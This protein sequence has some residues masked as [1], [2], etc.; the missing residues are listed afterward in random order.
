M[1]SSTKKRTLGK[2][3]ATLLT[4]SMIVGTGLYV[5]LGAA[6]FEAQS[7]ILIAMII[8]GII[9]LLTGLSGAQVG[10]NYPEEG[11]AFNWTR[12]FG[13][14]TISFIAGF[15]YLFD[16]VVGI[17]VLALGF[18]T[19]SAQVFPWL[20]IPLIASIAIIAVGAI[21]YFGIEPTSRVLIGIFLL[22]LILLGVYIAF[23][24]PKIQTANFSN[25]FGLGVGGILSGAATFFWAWDGFQRTAIMADEIKEPRKTIPFAVVVGITLAAAVYLIVAATTLGVLGPQKMGLTD[26]PIFLAAALTL[27]IGGVWLVFSSAWMTSFS[28]ML[29]DLLPTSK[30]AHSMGTEKEL[31]HQFGVLNKRFNS[32]QFSLLALIIIGIIL[33]TLFP[34]R[35]LIPIASAFTL[36][37]YIATHFSALKLPRKQHFISPIFSWLGLAACIG[38]IAFLPLWSIAISLAILAALAG[39]RWLFRKKRS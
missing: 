38:L 6:T 7:G 17:G 36:V 37:W 10:V 26:T 13:Y 22:N 19:Y 39:I 23:S 12:R 24:I 30:V 2:T 5:T 4:S 18:A 29:G 25:V 34:I 14:R 27:G 8:G 32:P 11:G 31:P 1:V 33:V 28:E 16:G 9:A 20:P 35:Q 3:A 15:A 21:N